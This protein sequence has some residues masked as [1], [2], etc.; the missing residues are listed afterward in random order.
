[1]TNC[2]QH[3][4]RRFYKALLQLVFSIHT[5][6]F[7]YSVIMVAF[8]VPSKKIY[9]SFHFP[10]NAGLEFLFSSSCRENKYFLGILLVFIWLNFAPL[11]IYFQN[12]LGRTYFNRKMSALKKE[13]TESQRSK[14]INCKVRLF[15][16]WVWVL[17]FL[18]FIFEFLQ[19]SMDTH[20]L[21]FLK[22]GQ[23]FYFLQSYIGEYKM[24]FLRKSL[25]LNFL[26]INSI[27]DSIE[28]NPITSILYAIP[29]VFLVIYYTF[30][31][32]INIL[33]LIKS[34]FTT[35]EEFEDR[36]KFDEKEYYVV[37]GAIK[38]YSF[39]TGICILS[40]IFFIPIVAE[41]FKQI[42]AEYSIFLKMILSVYIFFLLLV[43]IYPNWACYNK[44]SQL[45]NIYLS[46]KRGRIY[47]C[48]IDNPQSNLSKDEIDAITKRIELFNNVRP[49]GTYRNLIQ[50]IMIALISSAIPT[51]ITKLFT[52]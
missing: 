41:M 48:I 31:A 51:L 12:Q 32:L 15:L 24:F 4:I 11:L 5:V 44:F 6:T 9:A 52:Q 35:L 10:K 36:Q 21:S 8:L 18:F 33:I 3:N 26:H 43:F 17:L 40:G 20:Q 46:E 27:F 25:S 34:T 7:I 45:K 23:N 19:S 49:Q 16:F 42:T 2:E 14:Q 50:E 13:K 29:A 47:N 22:Q 37:S 38:R 30:I 39:V 1:M 28:G